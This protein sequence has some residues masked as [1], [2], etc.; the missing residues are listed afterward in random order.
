MWAFRATRDGEIL[1]PDLPERK[2]GGGCH[3][4]RWSVGGLREEPTLVSGKGQEKRKKNV[5]FG[6]PI[7]PAIMCV[8]LQIVSR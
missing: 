1:G 7:N 4:A 6:N 8:C 2:P 5:S 3:S